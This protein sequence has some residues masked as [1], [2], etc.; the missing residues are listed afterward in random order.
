MNDAQIYDR[1]MD[2]IYAV[3]PDKRWQCKFRVTPLMM[4][5]AKS[6]VDARGERVT[7]TYAGESRLLGFEVVIEG[8]QSAPAY[9]LKFTD[10]P[11]AQKWSDLE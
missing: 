8:D 6:V 11:D 1:M 7:W 4:Q 3:P 2:A 10:E 9:G 5:R